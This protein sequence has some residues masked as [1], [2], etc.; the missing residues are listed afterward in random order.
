[1]TGAPF[2]SVVRYCRQITG[3]GDAAPTDAE[4]LTRFLAR[5]DELAFAAL[6]ARHGS[7]VLAVGRSVLRDEHAAEDVF[8]ATFLVLARKASAI[9]KR[10]SVGS[11]L[12]GV[13]FR[14]ASN[15]KAKT[16]RRRKY[17]H[18]VARTV[19][20][21]GPDDPLADARALLLEELERLPDRYRQPLVLCY[22][23]GKTNE[24][25]AAALRW[26]VGTVKVRLARGR[27]TLRGRL[28]RRD[29]A[30]GAVLETVPSAPAPPAELAEAIIKV[31]VPFATGSAPAPDLVAAQVAALT[32]GVLRQMVLSKIRIVAVLVAALGVLAA[33]TGLLISASPAAPAAPVRNP[34]LR[35]PVS[36]SRVQEIQAQPAPRPEV[37]KAETPSLANRLAQ[38]PGELIRQKKSDAEIVDALYLSTLLR[39]PAKAEHDRLATLLKKATNREEAVRDILWALVN[40]TEFGL[41]HGIN[42]PAAIN[43]LADAIAEAWKKK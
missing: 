40:S 15:L 11:W 23:E 37:P 38:L 22:L 16:A 36:Q 34:D 42:D 31:A 43:A 25:A 2:E 29:P 35:P 13:A 12:Y 17:E 10:D 5:R 41:V 19:R 24:E 28:T 39:L 9:G 21:S 32:Q 1:M 3:D 27:A 6:V 14:V 7:M 20:T 30:F 8:Q 26:P 18:L 33:G 4:Y